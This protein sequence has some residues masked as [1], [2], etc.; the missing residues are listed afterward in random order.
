MKSSVNDLGC[1]Q[2][3]KVYNTQSKVETV[4]E[5]EVKEVTKNSIMNTLSLPL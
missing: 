5:S 1:E 3:E 4:S 2:L